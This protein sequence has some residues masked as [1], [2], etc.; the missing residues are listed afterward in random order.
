VALGCLHH[1]HLV[2]HSAVV[3]HEPQAAQ[4]RVRGAAAVSGQR[5]RALRGAC[6]NCAC[7]TAAWRRP[8]GSAT[9]G[10]GAQAADARCAR[11]CAG[12]CGRSQA[13]ASSRWPWRWPCRSQ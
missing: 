13:A 4:L 6:S 2:L 9:V 11:A 8:S 3:M 5:H 1:G 10:G 12:R 7:V